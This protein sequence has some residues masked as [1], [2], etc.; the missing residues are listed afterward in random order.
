MMNCTADI[1]YVPSLTFIVHFEQFR[2]K[3]C[4]M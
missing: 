4:S 2:L 3:L 1:R